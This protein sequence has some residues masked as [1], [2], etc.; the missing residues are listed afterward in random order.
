MKVFTK[1]MRYCVNRNIY[2]TTPKD[3]YHMPMTNIFVGCS[4]KA[5]NSVFH[6]WEC[7]VNQIRMAKEDTYKTTF[8]YPGHT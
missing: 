2:K 7:W 8:R 5:Q 4:G 1:A 3:E 6:G